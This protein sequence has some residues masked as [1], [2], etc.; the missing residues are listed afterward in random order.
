MFWMERIR[1][2]ASTLRDCDPFSLLS[3]EGPLPLARTHEALRAV[4]PRSIEKRRGEVKQTERCVRKLILRDS[5]YAQEKRHVNQFLDK[6]RRGMIAPSMLEELFAMI[7]SKCKD[8]IV[9]S[10]GG[11][12]GGHEPG[13]LGI[14]PADSGIVERDHFVAPSRKPA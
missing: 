10:L 9:P 7:G 13:N 1:A 2:A 11:T 4:E 12:Q 5:G 8:A 6:A 14:Y 3:T